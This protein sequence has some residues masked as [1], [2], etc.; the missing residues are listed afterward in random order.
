MLLAIFRLNDA[1]WLCFGF[2]LVLDV[3]GKRKYTH[4]FKRWKLYVER[5]RCLCCSMHPLRQ[6]HNTH[7]IHI[8][9]TLPRARGSRMKYSEFCRR[10]AHHYV[11]VLR[12]TAIEFNL[13]QALAHRLANANRYWCERKRSNRLMQGKAIAFPIEIIEIEKFPTRNMTRV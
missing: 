9:P 2:Y 11:N 8:E 1:R 12:D 13:R 10:F 5:W 6:A 4:D 3:D 7:T